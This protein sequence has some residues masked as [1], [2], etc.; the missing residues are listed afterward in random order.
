MELTPW[1]CPVKLALV[2][3]NLFQLLQGN[4]GTGNAWEFSSLGPA[5]LPLPIK[6][7]GNE[8][9]GGATRHRRQA[10][11]G[12]GQEED[13]TEKAEKEGLRLGSHGYTSAR[14]PIFTL[15]TF[16]EQQV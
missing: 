6:K 5:Y 12:R 4:Q 13:K 2:Y 11:D 14:W 8:R 16:N 15:G 10:K 1:F 3:G 7:G 9:R